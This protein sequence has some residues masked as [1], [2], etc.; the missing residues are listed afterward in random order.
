[1]DSLYHFLIRT[2]G[3]ADISMPFYTLSLM[4]DNVFSRL[5]MSP[6]LKAVADGSILLLNPDNTFPAPTSRK[7][8][9]PESMI[10]LTESSQRIG[11]LSWRKRDSFILVTSFRNT[12]SALLTTGTIAL[13]NESV[14]SKSES[15][16]EAL[17]INRQ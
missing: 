1:M 7:V 5:P 10:A 12:A 3:Y 2:P 9:T 6:M 15:F 13:L 17:S 11:Q 4:A 8:V 16:F 14:S